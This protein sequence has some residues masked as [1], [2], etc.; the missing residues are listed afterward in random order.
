MAPC[1]VTSLGIPVTK[2]YQLVISI[3]CVIQGQTGFAILS[4]SQ[5]TKAEYWDKSQPSEIID[6]N[7]CLT[8]AY[9]H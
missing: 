5:A 9:G 3:Q 1:L 2:F 6:S 4:S 8:F 7:K